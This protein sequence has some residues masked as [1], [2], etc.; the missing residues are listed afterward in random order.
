MAENEEQP[1][2][3]STPD[4]ETVSLQVSRRFNATAEQV[5]D[6]WLDAGALGKWLFKTPDGEMVR[7]EVDARIGGGFI[8]VEK[9]GDILAEHFGT[10][11]AIDRPH[12]LAFH[13][14]TDK[15]EKPSLVTIEIVPT[16]G[17]CELTLTHDM[18]KKW[19]DFV[20]RAKSG[21]SGILDGLAKTALCYH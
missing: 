21:W 1:N 14:T 6:A 4:A 12:R 7:A 10:Y 11:L 13:F 20:D 2:S 9:R 5:F 3:T 17:G 15:S 18:D 16:T 8:I 19:A